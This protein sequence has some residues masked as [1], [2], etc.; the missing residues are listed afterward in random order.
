M[1]AN[2]ECRMYEAA[3]P[4]VNEAV[5]VRVQR[6]SDTGVYVSLLEYGGIE[7]MV[8]LSE[9]SRRLIRSVTALAPVGRQEPAVVLRV[10]EA[11]GHVD[12]SRRRV[13]DED[14][15]RCNDRY[16]RSKLV[17]SVMR[18]VADTLDL[19]LEPLYR[20]VAWPL[21]R[22]YGHAFDAFKLAAADPDA[23]FDALTYE[24]EHTGPDGQQVT[25]IVPALTPEVKDVLVKNIIRRIIGQPLKI[26]A[27]VEMTCFH[28]D[29]VLH[30]KEAMRKAEAAGNDKCPVKMKLIA[31]PLYVLTT[32]T[33]DKEQGISVLKDAIKACTDA[34]EG[35]RGKLVVKVAPRAVSEREDKLLLDG[36]EKLQMDDEEV[37]SEED[38]E[39]EEE[40]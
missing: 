25:K 28:F 24:E 3:F 34:I 20:R 17:H 1:A 23:V 40:E 10:D 33:L 8:L 22:R 18:H 4:E 38:R 11:R 26:R 16:A 5:M 31:A 14:A 35:H 39:E 36:I 2:L 6:V 19:D 27:D 15:R 13:S 7:G 21:Y 32:Q 30:I 12:L 37:E 9:L 29:G